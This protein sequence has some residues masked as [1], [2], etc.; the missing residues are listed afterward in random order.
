MELFEK[1]ENF[2]D[3]NARKN[4][5]EG[6]VNPIQQPDLNIRPVGKYELSSDKIAYSKTSFWA[7]EQTP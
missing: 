7:I 4:F 1:Y 2:T 3:M 5:R 6:N